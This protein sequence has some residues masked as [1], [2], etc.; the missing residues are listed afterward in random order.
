MESQKIENRM[1]NIHPAIIKSLISEQAGTIHKAFA[2]LIMN[3]VDAEATEVFMTIDKSGAF[4]ISDNGKGF[5]DKK[6]ILNFFETFG[7]P[8]QENDAHYGKFRVGRGQIMAF[9]ETTW[10]SGYFEMHVDLDGVQD[11]FGYSLKENE[12]HQ[13]GCLVE[14]N[15]Y[16]NHIPHYFFSWYQYDESG[17]DYFISDITNLIKFMPIPIFINKKQVNTLPEDKK[18][19]F[20]DDFAYYFFDR[21]YDHFSIFNKGVF[22][23]N[24]DTRRV[25]SGGFI[26]TKESLLINLARNEIR[27][28]CKIWG[29][30]E[31]VI[32]DRFLTKVSKVKKLSDVESTRVLFDAIHTNNTMPK[33]IKSKLFIPNIFGELKSPLDMLQNE[34]FTLFDD[35]HIQIAEKVQSE[36]LATV[37]T[38]ELMYRC[39]IKKNDFS[40]EI[41]MLISKLRTKLLHIY[42][43]FQIIPFHYFVKELAD[44]YSII[45]K[46][47][48]KKDQ[49]LIMKV[50]DSFQDEIL[51]L[52]PQN[53]R[54]I[55]RVLKIGISQTNL[56]WTDGFSYIAIS[57]NVLKTFKDGQYENSGGILQLILILIHEYCHNENSTGTHGHDINF[58]KKYHNITM[59]S[60]LQR[61]LERMYRYSIKLMTVRE[62]IPSGYQRA[63]IEA[64]AKYEPLLTRRSKKK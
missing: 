2:E 37:I 45:E 25:G 57:E 31:S 21:K 15:I 18:W 34:R 27:Q 49:Q 4:T 3:S 17:L 55:K 16:P 7:T 6:E 61:I 11:D 64:L 32:S 28:E 52:F 29:H 43:D 35:F 51:R 36:N 46:K 38:P 13:A 24:L 59:N 44:T 54:P 39:G 42:K 9:A 47:E 60:T 10:K 40:S 5:K 63:H 22:V 1:F 19:D 30:I 41:S 12:E 20:E 53:N 56:G 50:L 58:Y 62:V 48:W 14:G 8:H 26:T 33:D 23:K